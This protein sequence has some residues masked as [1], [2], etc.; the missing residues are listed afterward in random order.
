MDGNGKN[1][2]SAESRRAVNFFAL[3]LAVAGY[4]VYLGFDLLRGYL[5]GGSTLSPLLAWIC[6]PGFMAAGLVFALY[7]WRRYKRERTAA[8]E[9]GEAP[10]TDE[11]SGGE[12]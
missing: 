12:D 2:Q 8:P 9:R 10:E 6:G 5:A 1:T 7:S 11:A 4:L 3:R